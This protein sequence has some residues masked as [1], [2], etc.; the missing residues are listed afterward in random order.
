M[1]IHTGIMGYQP[2]TTAADLF[3]IH[4]LVKRQLLELPV[5]AA[6]LSTAPLVCRSVD[7]VVLLAVA[8]DRVVRLLRVFEKVL[9]E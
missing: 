4:L 9:R 1:Y 6:E 2:I 8:D 7:R 3:N 5:A